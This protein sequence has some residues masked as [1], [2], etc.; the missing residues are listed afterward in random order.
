MLLRLT[1]TGLPLD[2]VRELTVPSDYSVYELHLCLQVALGW[3]D[4]A[5]FE[6]VRRG[7]TVGTEPSFAGEGITHDGHR[8]RHADEVTLRQL[9]GRVGHEATYTYD[10]SKLWGG[11]LRVLDETRGDD[12]GLP[13]CTH[14]EGPAPPEDLD[15]KAAFGLLLDA[16]ADEAHE[17][18]P[19]A[20]A[21]LGDAYNVVPPPADLLTEAL[22]ELFGEEVAPYTDGQDD[23]EEGWGWWDPSK[24]DDGMRLR[25]LRE[26]LERELPG[27]VEGGS[28]GE[29]QASLLRAL[30]GRRAE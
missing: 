6:F 3:Q 26:E 5:D 13:A 10:F 15:E 16:Y 14:A 8:Y 30:R 2:V 21:A 4:N 29:R 17:L 1:L 25:V 24:Y 19:V 22:R 23:D 28:A 11:R 27:A 7:L 18:Y 9:I 20:W 12:E